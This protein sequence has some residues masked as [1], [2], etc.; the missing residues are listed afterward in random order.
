MPAIHIEPAIRAAAPGYTC[1]WL[2]ADVVNRPTSETLWAD[3][4]AVCQS[5]LANATLETLNKQGPILAMR[6]LYKKLGKDPNRYRPSAEAL[7]RRL[8][9][10]KGLYRINSLVDIINGLSI[11]TG[12]SIGGFDAAKVEG[13]LSIGVGREDEP[14]EAIGRGR[15]NIEG[16]PVYR[17]AKGPIGTPTSDVERT[18]LCL[19]TTRLLMIVHSAGG[20]EGLDEALQAARR[21]LVD[22]AEAV[23]IEQGFFSEQ[24]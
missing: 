22:Y 5:F 12:F 9:L 7:C 11:K 16:L 20:P 3:L 23:N 8:V 21:L 24:R 18:K 10:G 14:F 17:D 1:A 4:D 15:L 2:T 13:P 6:Q 19:E